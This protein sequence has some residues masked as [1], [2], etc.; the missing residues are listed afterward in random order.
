VRAYYYYYYYY[1]YY[2]KLHCYYANESLHFETSTKQLQLNY[3]A[4]IK[5]LRRQLYGLF[6]LP[7]L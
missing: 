6:Y 1:Y 2:I 7:L 5:C 4:E 3:L